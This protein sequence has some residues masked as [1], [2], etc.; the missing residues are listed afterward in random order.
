ML[1]HSAPCP[2]VP[3]LPLCFCWVPS[4][5]GVTGTERVDSLARNISLTER[6]RSRSLPASDYYPLFRQDIYNHPMANVLVHHCRQYTSYYQTFSS[7]LVSPLSQKS[8]LGNCPRPLT[9]WPHS[10][11]PLLPHVPLLSCSL[12]PLSCPTFSLSHSPFLP[13][14]LTYPFC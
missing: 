5:V 14:P 13:S 4:H 9:N 12:P 11:N 3:H 2:I 7:P 1:S 10:P 6:L 8:P